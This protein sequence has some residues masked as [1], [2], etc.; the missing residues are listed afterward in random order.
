MTKVS[1]AQWCT[2]DRT[3]IYRNLDSVF[4]AEKQAFIENGRLCTCKTTKCNSISF[5]KLNNIATA[6]TV[7][8]VNI[9]SESTTLHLELSDVT[10]VDN[11]STQSLAAGP[12]KFNQMLM[13]ILS[14]LC[15]VCLMFVQLTRFNLIV[16]KQY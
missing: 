16:V 3:Q 15:S 14:I 12:V 8:A 7:S 11:L 6:P 4:R 1:A 13:P 5:E 9:T 2:H 10:T